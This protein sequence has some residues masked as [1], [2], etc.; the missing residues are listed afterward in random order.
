MQSLISPCRCCIHT[1]LHTSKH[2]HPEHNM[3]PSQASAEC[4]IPRKTVAKRLQT[5]RYN[6]TGWS[7]RAH[8]TH[9]TSCDSYNTLEVAR[10]EGVAPFFSLVAESGKKAQCAFYSEI[11]EPV[12]AYRWGLRACAQAKVLRVRPPTRNFREISCFRHPPANFGKTFAKVC[13]P[14]IDGVPFAIQ[15]VGLVC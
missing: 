2:K 1:S 10:R 14:L 4:S 12:S 5:N 6:V 9:T 7:R 11:V 8:M 3:I 13:P 15:A